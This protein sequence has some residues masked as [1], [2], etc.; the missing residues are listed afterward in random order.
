MERLM[1]SDEESREKARKT[2][3]QLRDVESEMAKLRSRNEILE[4]KQQR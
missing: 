4:K 3:V 1:K 2:V